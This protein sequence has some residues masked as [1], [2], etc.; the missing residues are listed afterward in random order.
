MVLG[1]FSFT[2]ITDPTLHGAY[3]QWHQFDHLPEQFTVDGIVFGQRWVASPRCQQARVAVS[4]RLEPCHYMTLYLLRDATVLPPFFALATR[5]HDEGR[6]FTARASHLTGDFGRTGCWA[7][8]RVLVSPGAVPYRPAAG[9]Y[10]V[11]G[12]ALD[13]AALVARDGVAGAWQ[14]ADAAGESHITVAFL[15]T[16]LLATAAHLGPWCQ[17]LGAPLEWAGP[18]ET[19][20][21]NRWDWFDRLTGP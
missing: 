13:G 17:D 21:P 8:P 16:D 20:D 15:D 4:S 10:V 12:P 1:F 2:E 3:N 5:L 19:I 14:F 7:A 9:V 6:W 11:V 18:L